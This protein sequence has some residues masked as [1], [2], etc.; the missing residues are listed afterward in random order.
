MENHKG[1]GRQSKSKHKHIFFIHYYYLQFTFFLFIQMLTYCFCTSHIAFLHPVILFL[2]Y[3][4]NHRFF[5]FFLVGQREQNRRSYPKIGMHRQVNICAVFD[6]NLRRC[7]LNQYST[8]SPLPPAT[9][10][11]HCFQKIHLETAIG[12]LIVP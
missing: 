3:S 7:E 12:C 4:N 9:F 1:H 2:L 10:R 6:Q 5:V 8:A 11:G